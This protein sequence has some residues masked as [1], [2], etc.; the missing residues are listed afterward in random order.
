MSAIRASQSRRAVVA[1]V[2]AI[3]TH[4]VSLA[5]AI[6]TMTSVTGACHTWNDASDGFARGEFCGAV[7]LEDAAVSNSAAASQMRMLGS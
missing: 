3:L 1:G 2:N 6:A 5:F 7:V 4:H